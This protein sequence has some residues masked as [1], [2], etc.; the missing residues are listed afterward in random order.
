LR[1]TVDLDGTQ[2]YIYLARYPRQQPNGKVTAT[3]H[4]LESR[5]SRQRIGVVRQADLELQELELT[6]GDRR[7][8]VWSWYRVGGRNASSLGSA[9][10]LEIV[11]VLRG[12]PTGALVVVSAECETTCDAQRAILERFLKSRAADLHLLADKG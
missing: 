8:L 9:K 7:R 3:S 4:D 5:W 12:D 6:R 2:G 10:L 1:A 11:G